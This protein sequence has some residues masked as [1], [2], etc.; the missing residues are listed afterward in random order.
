MDETVE[1]IKRLRELDLWFKI[2]MYLVPCWCLFWVFSIII[3]LHQSS[4]VLD[5][6]LIVVVWVLFIAI[7]LQRFYLD[8]ESTRVLSKLIVLG[9]LENKEVKRETYFKSLLD[10]MLEHNEYFDFETH[11]P[12]T[13]L[14]RL[15]GQKVWKLEDLKIDAT[16][17]HV[18][19][20]FY[21]L[22]LKRHIGDYQHVINRIAAKEKEVK[23]EVVRKE[24]EV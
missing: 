3:R 4:T 14:R 10:L 12:V 11:K 21:E 9:Y 20:I 13:F 7:F 23:V 2:D 17:S 6:L 15:N 1:V 19:V 5:V 24:E 16:V 18:D 8:Y 22:K